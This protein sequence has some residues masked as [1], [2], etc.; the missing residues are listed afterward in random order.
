VVLEL[1]LRARVALERR[2][3][4]RARR[5][6]RL[7]AREARLDREL[8]GAAGQ[9]VGLDRA[10]RSRGG[11]W[12]WSATRT[13]FAKLSSP[14]SIE[15]S[16]ASIRSSV[17]L[18]A[19]LRPAIVIRSRRSSL[20]ETPRSSGAP[21]MSLERLEA[22]QTAIALMVCGSGLAPIRCRD[23][24]PDPRDSCNLVGL[25]VVTP[26]AFAVGGEGLLGETSDS[27]ITLGRL[28]P[29]HL[30]PALHR[31]RASSSGTSRSASTRATTPAR[32]GRRVPSGAAAGSTAGFAARSHRLPA[33]GVSTQTP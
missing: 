28:H 8:R 6:L 3:V 25:L 31:S 11:R 18:P 1:G 30:L 17:V 23:A 10:P 12:S 26:A 16:P 32:R 14:P 15:S 24:A 33:G 27:T 4:A 29:D 9:Q 22:M 20:N 21:A 19:P 5:H 7:E 2:L 13:P